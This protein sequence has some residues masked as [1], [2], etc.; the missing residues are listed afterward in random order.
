VR[1]AKFIGQQI[2]LL[3]HRIDLTRENQ[4]HLTHLQTIERTIRRRKAIRHAA[5]IMARQRNIS[6]REA[7]SFMVAYARRNRRNL[8]EI[9][10]ALI[11][12]YHSVRFSSSPLKVSPLHAR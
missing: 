10:E 5:V 11:F 9:S 12:G 4:R 3:L 8:L 7:L 1:L 6:E 2:G